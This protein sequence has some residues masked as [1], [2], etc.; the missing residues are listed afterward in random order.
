MRHFIFATIFCIFF[1]GRSEAAP[2]WIFDSYGNPITFVGGT[3]PVSGTFTASVYGQ[4]PANH[5]R[6][7]YTVTPVTSSAYVQLLGSTSAVI[8]AIEIFDSSGQTLVLAFG[9][10]GSEVD[11]IYI[12]P[13]GNGR[14]PLSIPS[15]TRVSIKAVTA[16]ASA[17]YIDANFYN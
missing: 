3:I 17:G 10:M 1:A 13:G 16:T 15:G 4:T 6:N 12:I 7:D 2:A 5:A 9:A 11:Q 14:I 8:N